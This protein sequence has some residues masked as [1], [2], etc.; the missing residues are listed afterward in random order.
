LIAA[1]SALEAGTVDDGTVPFEAFSLS[2]SAAA[3]DSNGR[4][5]S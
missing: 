1:R 4:E 5:M 2:G 3:V